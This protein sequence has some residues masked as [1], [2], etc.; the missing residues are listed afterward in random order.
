MIKSTRPSGLRSSLH[1]EVFNG[2][3]ALRTGSK[4]SATKHMQR[5]WLSPSAQPLATGGRPERI[6]P[7]SN[8]PYIDNVPAC[9]DEGG[10]KQT[11]QDL[12]EAIHGWRRPGELT[13]GHLHVYVV[14][15]KQEHFWPG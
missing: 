14:A 4:I 3:V 13:G 2:A 1:Y 9:Y 11:V 6:L 8:V 10:N 15:L 5:W 7:R 12:L